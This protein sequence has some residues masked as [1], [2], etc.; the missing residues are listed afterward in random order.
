MR[1]QDAFIVGYLYARDANPVAFADDVADAGKAA[2]EPWA[3]VVDAQ[4]NGIDS[5]LAGEIEHGKSYRAARGVD[6]RTDDAAMD[7]LL[8]KVANVFRLERDFDDSMADAQLLQRKAKETVEGDVCIEKSANLIKKRLLVG[9]TIW[10]RLF[11][12]ARFH[13]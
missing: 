11:C 3:H 12:V 2:P 10:P 4:V 13:R 9:H 6:Q 8:A 5:D 1:N 7:N